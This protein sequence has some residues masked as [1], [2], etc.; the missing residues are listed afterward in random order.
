MYHERKKPVLA[1]VRIVSERDVQRY[2]AKQASN[3]QSF[4]NVDSTA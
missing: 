2:Y 1:I 4:L 3:L